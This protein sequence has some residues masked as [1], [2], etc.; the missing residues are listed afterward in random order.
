MD[1]RIVNYYKNTYESD[2]DKY[3][4]QEYNDGL[5]VSPVLPKTIGYPASTP[6]ESIFFA[7]ITWF[8]S[9]IPQVIG[10]YCGKNAMLHFHKV[11]E[12]PILLESN[13][14]IHPFHTLASSMLLPEVTCYKM[15]SALGHC[16]EFMIPSL[17][18]LLPQL[19]YE[20]DVNKHINEITHEILK[21]TSDFKWKLTEPHK[22][23]WFDR[24]IPCV[25]RPFPIYY[26]K[27]GEVCTS[28][29]GDEYCLKES[30]Y[31]KYISHYFIG[32]DE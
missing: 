9:L 13:N 1:Y 31:Y 17:E 30:A 18:S 28:I 32:L 20:C 3:F 6:S 23:P 21:V 11:A 25:Y 27:F 7:S 22:W 26:Y 16:E 12:W 15:A 8:I 10:V 4:T 2:Y 19:L 24:K 5:I 14:L 29:V